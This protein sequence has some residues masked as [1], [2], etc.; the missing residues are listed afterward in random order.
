M[1]RVN[2]FGQRL[3]TLTPCLLMTAI[4][5][6]ISPLFP[7]AF[8]SSACANENSKLLILG[9]SISAGYGIP[10]GKGWVTLL[11]QKFQEQGQSVQI[12]ND[13]ISGDTTAGGLARLPKVLAAI[14][15]S[16]VLIALGGNDGLRGQSLQAMEA[17]L[18]QM[19]LISQ[20]SGA[21]PFL[22]GIKLPPNYGKAYTQEFELV[23]ANVSKATNTPLLPFFI[24]GVGGNTKFM[25]EDRIHPN[26]KAQAIIQNNV[27]QFIAPLMQPD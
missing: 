1:N 9:D 12:I 3:A 15:P 21:K 13:S 2:T 4:L 25:Q 14:K 16:W 6:L 23:F 18:A 19:V 11:Q 26:I 7:S 8:F 20:Q 24:D 27:W 10:E 5:T 22:L 17:N